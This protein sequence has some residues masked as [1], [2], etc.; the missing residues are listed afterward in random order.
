MRKSCGGI[1]EAAWSVEQEGAFVERR[2]SRNVPNLPDVE[3]ELVARGTHIRMK[4]IETPEGCWF[5]V[6]PEQ[7]R[8]GL[9]DGRRVSMSRS[10]ECTD[11]D[12][13]R[14]GGALTSSPG[15][16]GRAAM[17][18][19]SA[20]ECRLGS[21]QLQGSMAIVVV[22]SMKA[23]HGL[24]VGRSV[25]KV[26]ERSCCAVTTPTPRFRD[27]RGRSVRNPEICV[28]LLCPCL[29]LETR[30]QTKRDE[31]WSLESKNSVQKQ[32]I[33]TLIRLQDRGR[34]DNQFS[35][36]LPQRW[37]LESVAEC[38]IR[39]GSK[40]LFSTSTPNTPSPAAT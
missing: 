15:E 37:T 28:V 9:R 24:E 25:E 14:D 38:D 13:K 10:S 17:L 23:M 19:A 11:L 26:E 21:A 1:V 16:G 12:Y 4:V 34:A 8:G 31:C 39:E 7:K 36:F 2:A 32:M 27:A 6:D 5:D 40:N 20:F 18:I 22:M 29:I 35:S 3:L 30:Q 33:E